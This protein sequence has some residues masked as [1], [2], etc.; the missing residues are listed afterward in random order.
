MQT[1]QTD[2]VALPP[3]WIKICLGN[4]C[5]LRSFP[6]LLFLR[7]PVLANDFKIFVTASP[8]SCHRTADLSFDY[9]LDISTWMPRV[10]SH[11]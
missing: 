11:L 9:F 6:A 3:P 1:V 5:H 8:A 2:N 7:E 4:K 10:Q